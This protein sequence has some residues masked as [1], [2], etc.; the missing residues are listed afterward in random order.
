MLLLNN[1][2]NNNKANINTPF[3]SALSLT[4]TFPHAER[5]F[6]SELKQV[7]LCGGVG[8]QARP[9]GHQTLV[10][11]AFNQFVKWCCRGG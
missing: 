9:E 11:V 7:L 6:N 4:F 10:N 5:S 8:H 1:N 2:N 3:S